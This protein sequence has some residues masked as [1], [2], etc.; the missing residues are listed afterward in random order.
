MAKLSRATVLLL[1]V[2]PLCMY[3]FAL[4]VGVQLGQALE[5]NPDVRLRW[6]LE[7][8]IPKSLGGVVEFTWRGATFDH[9]YVTKA[10]ASIS[11]SRELIWDTNVSGR[12]G[13]GGRGHFFVNGGVR[14]VAVPAVVASRSS[15]VESSSSSAAKQPSGADAAI[16]L[17]SQSML[18]QRQRELMLLQR[19]RALQMQ[20]LSQV[21]RDTTSNNH[22]SPRGVISVGPWGGSGGQPFYMRG[23]SAPRLRSIVLYHSGAIH[24]L[25]CEYTLA[26]DYDGPPPPPRVA[27]PWGLPYSFGSRGVRAKIDL[28]S[29]EYITAVEGT[30]GHFANVPGVV[31]TSLTFRTSAG[32]THGPF[33]SVAA[34]SSHYFSIPAADDACIV[35]F[36]GRS[37]WLLDAIGV[38]MKPS[39]SSSYYTAYKKYYASRR[40]GPN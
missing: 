9:R 33:G 15:G 37:G 3:T 29:G 31:I 27:G 4:L 8:L 24:S 22:T 17:P 30:T 35:G 5:R 10:V 6:T 11:S 12:G 19:Q 25:S 13:G 14:E 28:A 39:C 2:V 38:Y 21:S 34:G 32:R 23:A 16:T 36:W 40:H 20:L 18:L 1:V 26:G 7:K